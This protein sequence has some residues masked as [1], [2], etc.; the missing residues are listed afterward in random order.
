MSI[1]GYVELSMLGWWLGGQ[2]DVIRRWWCV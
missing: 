2:Y 1:W